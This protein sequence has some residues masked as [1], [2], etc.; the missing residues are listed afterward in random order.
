MPYIAMELLEGEDLDQPPPQARPLAP[1]ETLAVAIQVGRALTK[2]HA[3]GLVHR[4]LKPAN[5]FL[6]RDDDREIAKV[7][8]FGV[9]K[10]NGLGHRRQH[11][12]GR[13]ARHALLHEPGAG[14]RDQDHRPPLRPLGAGRGRLPVPDG[15]AALHERGA[16]RSLRE[17]HRRAAARAVP[18]RASVPPAFDAWWARAA[19]RDPA[20]RFQT[21]KEFIEA[22]GLALGVTAVGMGVE[23]GSAMAYAG[24]GGGVPAGTGTLAL[25]PSRPLTP[26]PGG[27]TPQPGA[28]PSPSGAWAARSAPG[29]WQGPSAPGVVPQSGAWQAGGS[30]PRVPAAG[31]WARP[32]RRCSSRSPCPPPPRRAAPA[33]SSPAW[34]G[35]RRWVGS[36]LRAPQRRSREPDGGARGLGSA[37]GDCLGGSAG[38]CL[39]AGR[40]RD[41][42]RGARR[43]RGLGDRACGERVCLRLRGEGTRRPRERSRAGEAPV[44][45]RREVWPAARFARFL[46]PSMDPR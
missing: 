13:R 3:A 9:A 8:D 27:G 24:P 37:A 17:D 41:A 25:T 46:K 32:R 1:Q 39:G 18:G 45:R 19:A 26:Y 44:G 36:V 21:A 34:S 31:D 22:L 15:P 38:G 42:L 28:V 20:Q 16:R 35:S 10:V 7:L 6:V 29:T 5:I 2:A 43:R 12:D 30:A 11:Q 14:P 4:D 33:G 40:E 23:V